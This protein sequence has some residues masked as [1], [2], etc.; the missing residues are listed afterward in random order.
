MSGEGVLAS[1]PGLPTSFQSALRQG[2]A[3]W[4]ATRRIS[5]RLTCDDVA[6]RIGLVC[7]GSFIRAI[8]AAVYRPRDI[9]AVI[10]DPLQGLLG[11]LPGTLLPDT[12]P[13]V[14]AVNQ[15][16]APAIAPAAS[17]GSAAAGAT[18]ILRRWT[19]TLA[20]GGDAAWRVGLVVRGDDGVVRETPLEPE[21]A[22]A[23]GTELI[24]YAE[25]A[26]G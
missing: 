9:P 1:D 17:P 15:L 23:L 7:S 12:D 26:A 13:M 18:L 6:R 19:L 24:K 20:R 14:D 16:A 2:L 3:D 4:C 11:E 21:D 22:T 8:E 5:M 25:L 10:L